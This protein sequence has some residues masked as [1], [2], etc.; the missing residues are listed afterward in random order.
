MG[1]LRQF[2]K[3]ERVQLV[4]EDFSHEGFGVGKVD[5][6]TVFVKDTVIGDEVEVQMMK[7]KKTYGYARLVKLRKSS[8]HR[9][10]PR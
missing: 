8:K 10:T 1:Q 9:V 4:I 3:N 7:L 5:G 6:Y 2:Q